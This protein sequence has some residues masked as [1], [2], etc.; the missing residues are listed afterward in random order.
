MITTTRA[1]S[2]VIRVM[3]TSKRAMS[4]VIRAMITAATA[5]SHVIQAILTFTTSMSHKIQA[6]HPAANTIFNRFPPTRGDFHS[7]HAR[8]L[9]KQYLFL[10][11]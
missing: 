10:L 5:I 2:H 1:M 7:V 4:N 3:R 6:I 8:K 9:K 11:F